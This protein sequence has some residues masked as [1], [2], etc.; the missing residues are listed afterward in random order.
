MSFSEAA[1]GANVQ[2]PTLNG[3]V[4]LKIPAGTA[5]GRTFR[6]RGKGAP[7]PRKGGHGDMLVT[8]RVDVPSKLSREQK[9]LLKRLQDTEGESPR[10]RLGM[11]A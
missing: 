1:L 4:T 7:H 10:R 11:E 6:I 3:S 8:V 5:A 2:V 9:E